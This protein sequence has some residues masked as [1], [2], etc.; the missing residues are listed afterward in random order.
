MSSFEVQL[1]QVYAGRMLD[2]EVSQELEAFVILAEEYGVVLFS[3]LEGH[4]GFGSDRLHTF[5]YS[6][7]L[8]VL[9]EG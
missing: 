1:L 5:L 6:L 7:E 4:D 8:L 2:K 3:L 9:L